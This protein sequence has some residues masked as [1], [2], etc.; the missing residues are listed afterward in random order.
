MLTHA[1]PA[2]MRTSEAERQRVAEFLRDACADGR[3]S[4]DEL[5]QRLD[6]LFAGGTVGDIERLVW[7]LPGGQA[8]VPRLSGAPR[9]PAPVRRRPAS[10]MRPA[11]VALI[12][13]GVAA[14]ILLSLPPFLAVVSLAILLATAVALA[15]IAAALAPAGL[16]LFG[17]G[18]L[19]SRLWRGRMG[20]HP[21]GWP[22]GRGGHPFG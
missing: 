4:A 15:A 5:E 20:A 10:P 3:L 9:V 6:R 22:G 11:A 7:D 16:I 14:L 13:F 2:T 17:I 21:H 1:R 19:I 18:W 8:V 12:C